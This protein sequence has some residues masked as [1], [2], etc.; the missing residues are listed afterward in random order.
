MNDVLIWSDGDYF[1]HIIKVSK[2]LTKL[3]AAGLKLDLN[4]CEFVVK[5]VKYLEFIITAEE[6]IKV[7]SEKV[8][9]IRE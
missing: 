1:N 2:I 3:K 4:K 5:E 6:G 9:V 8:V 7:D